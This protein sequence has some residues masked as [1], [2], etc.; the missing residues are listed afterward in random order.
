MLHSLAD[1]TGDLARLLFNL[2]ILGVGGWL[3]WQVFLCSKP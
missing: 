1:T 2:A 3:I